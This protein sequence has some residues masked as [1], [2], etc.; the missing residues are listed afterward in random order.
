MIRPQINTETGE[1][2]CQTIITINTIIVKTKPET[3]DGSKWIVVDFLHLRR[4][5]L[6]E[7]FQNLLIL[8][9]MRLFVV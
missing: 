9:K 1:R 2:I 4:D 7:I 5:A 8:R 6:V 3:V